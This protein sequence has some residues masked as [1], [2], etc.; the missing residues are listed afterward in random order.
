MKEATGQTPLKLVYGSEALLPV[1]IGVQ[2]IRVKHFNQEE[3][4]QSRLLDLEL[5]DEVKENAT[6][7]MAAY[8]NR[9]TRLYNRKV[10]Y[11]MFQVGDLIL[12]NTKATQKHE[13][14]KLS[15]KWVG[16]YIISENCGNGTYKLKTSDREP[17]KHKC[18]IRMFKNYYV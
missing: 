15:E 3:N 17:L 4:V 2:T 6:L 9:I 7:K 10:K 18:N 16:P 5:I 11:R 8:Q 12:R 14:E 1:E 13:H